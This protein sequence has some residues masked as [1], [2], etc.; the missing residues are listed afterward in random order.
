MSNPIEKYFGLKDHGTNFRIEFIAGLT[1]F[2]TMAYIIFVNPAILSIAGMDKGSVFVATIVAAVIGTLIMGLFA[3]V[4]FAQAPGMGM[5]AFFTFTV[6]MVMGYTWQQALAFVLISGCVNILVTATRL[7]KTLILAIPE[8]LQFAISGGIGLFIAYIGIKNAHFLNF[9]LDGSV[10]NGAVGNVIPSLVNFTDPVS[11]L[12]IIGLFI[13]VVLLILRIQGAIL[14]GILLITIIGIFMKVTVI[15]AINAK[16][17]IPPSIAPTF[18]QLDIL[19]LF[20]GSVGIIS[21]FPALTG[22]VGVFGLGQMIWFVWLAMVLLRSS[23]AV[24][25]Q[26]HDTFVLRHTT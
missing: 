19:G 3:N 9:T 14:W 8:F 17:F 1:T 12:A 26:P 13:T 16:D 7:R 10:V 6:V 20:V 23:V 5:N 21:I 24:T 15:P 2:L 4:P 11:L 22:L 25:V 18:F